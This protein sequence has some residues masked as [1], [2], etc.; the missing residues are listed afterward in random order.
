LEP[1]QVNRK[2]LRKLFSSPQ[3]VARMIAAGWITVVRKG[4][5]GRETLYDYQSATC[6]YQR[7]KNGEVPPLLARERKK[8]SL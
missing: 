2:E 6:A 1:F 7:L 4:K 3:L 8:R 5:P